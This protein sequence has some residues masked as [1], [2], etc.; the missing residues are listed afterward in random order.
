MK[1]RTGRA[2]P[3]RQFELL[4]RRAGDVEEGL[5][6][7]REKRE[8]KLG[9]DFIAG[10]VTAPGIA[11]ALV[12]ET[13]TRFGR[14]DILVNNAGIVH[15]GTVLETSD[16]DFAQIM[17]VNV[18]A[19]FRFSRAAVRHMIAQFDADG[20]GGAVVNIASDWAFVAGRGELAYCTSK[21]AVVQMTRALAIDHARQGIRVNAVAPGDVE[22][23]M[24]LSGIAD[25]GK[26]AAEGLRE[27]GDRIPMGRVG[28]P[29]EIASAVAFL[30]GDEASF[31]TG[32]TLMVDGGNTAI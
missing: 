20:R 7:I 14:I 22:T 1:H 15:S 8:P 19:V 12:Q 13:V 6:A 4:R 25:R 17:A 21:G 30:A 2:E 31:V 9:A 29:A 24:L 26:S 28:R 23:P 3:V 32:T 10:D 11:D 16:D 5:T 18:V 27:N